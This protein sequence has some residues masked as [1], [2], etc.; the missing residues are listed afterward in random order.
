[1]PWDPEKYHQFEEERSR[2]FLDLLGVVVVRPRLQ[3]VDLG[4]GTGELTRKLAEALPESQ[5][6][7]MDSSPE[8]LAKSQVWARNGLHFE[9]GNQAELAGSWDLIF[10]NAALQWSE[11]HKQ[12]VPRL[13]RCLK[14]GG[15]IAVQVPSNHN[16]ISHQIYREIAAQEPFAGPLKGYNRQSPVLS[17][18]AYA[19]LLF[20][21]GARDILVFEKVYPHVL[22]DAQAVVDWISSTALLP[23]FERLDEALRQKF[24]DAIRSRMQR[25]FPSSPVFYPFKRTFFSARRA[26]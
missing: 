13:F 24:L 9:I 25:E 20:R 17:I 11:D 26:S 12:L 3:V 14:P 10:S 19:D 8:M 2:P 15:Q 4:C 18:E 22:Q 7:G 6:T 21:E 16:H 5:V 1:M 23:Y